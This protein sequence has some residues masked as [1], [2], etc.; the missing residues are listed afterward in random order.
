[1]PDNTVAPLSG[2]SPSFVSIDPEPSAPASSAPLMCIDKASEGGE[3]ASGAGSDALVRKFSHAS[4]AGGG[5][6]Y[7]DMPKPLPSSCADDGLRALAACSATTLLGATAL[8]SAGTTGMGLLVSAGS[9]AG[10]VEG[11]LECLATEKEASKP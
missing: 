5:S 10:N 4:G 1:M 9:C 3:G 11:Y 2:T 6:G 7:V 8:L